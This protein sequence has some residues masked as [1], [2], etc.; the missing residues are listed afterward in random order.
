M[1]KIWNIWK[2]VIPN[3]SFCRTLKD[4]NKNCKQCKDNYMFIRRWDSLA[5]LLFSVWRCCW[6]NLLFETILRKFV[7]VTLLNDEM[8]DFIKEIKNL[9]EGSS[10]LK[11]EYSRKCFV[12]ENTFCRNLG[13]LEIEFF[14]LLCQVWL[15]LWCH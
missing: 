1:T 12:L 15:N 11:I 7:L 5:K 2:L 13:A 6:K 4:W 9:L 10:V 3:L 14:P 8:M